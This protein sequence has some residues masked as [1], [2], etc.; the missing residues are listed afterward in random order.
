[1]KARGCMWMEANEGFGVHAFNTAGV[2]GLSS[3]VQAVPSPNEPAV[4]CVKQRWVVGNTHVTCHVGVPSCGQRQRNVFIT[5]LLTCVI[6]NIILSHSLASP[7]CVSSLA[8]LHRHRKPV[9]RSPVCT[10][11]QKCSTDMTTWHS[12]Q[13][14]VARHCKLH[15]YYALQV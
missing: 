12:K 2:M 1:L 8:S 15:R 14:P 3:D 13:G 5:L 9:T 6:T 11:A 4:R 10:Q 7:P